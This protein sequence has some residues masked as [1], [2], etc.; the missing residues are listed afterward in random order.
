MGTP[1]SLFSIVE[2]KL[3][4]LGYYVRFVNVH[5]LWKRVNLMEL[6]KDIRYL[7]SIKM[8]KNLFRKSGLIR[9]SIKYKYL[10]QI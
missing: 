8:H 3:L 9:S 10:Y 5:S 6:D 4:P 1:S 7:N 2:I